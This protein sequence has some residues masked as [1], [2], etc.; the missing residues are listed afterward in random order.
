MVLRVL[1]QE[2]PLMLYSTDLKQVAFI[3][4]AAADFLANHDMETIQLGRHD[5]GNDEFVNVMEFTPGQREEKSY[6][7]HKDY[8]DIQ[9][10]IR[11]AEICEVAPLSQCQE[12]KPY[13][14]KNDIAFHSNA[15]QGE[16]YLLAPGRFIVVWPEDAHMPGIALCEEPELVRKA[17]FKIRA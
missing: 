2:G 9:M 8:L 7:T 6:E 11:G 12:L 14:Q 17:V 4:Q 10:V 16:Q 15:T 3:S 13:D 5:L 1:K